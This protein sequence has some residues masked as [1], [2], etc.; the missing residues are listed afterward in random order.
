[1]PTHAAAVSWV[2]CTVLLRSARTFGILTRKV[3]GH[4][5]TLCADRDLAACRSPA[6]SPLLR[7]VRSTLHSNHHIHAF[8]GFLRAWPPRLLL[9]DA[10]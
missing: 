6:F 1:M 3:L 9:A 8:S 5:C 2:L 4:T 7:Q 10:P